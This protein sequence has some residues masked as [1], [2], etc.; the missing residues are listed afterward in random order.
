MLTVTPEVNLRPGDRLRLTLT[1]AVRDT[2]GEGIVT[3]VDGDSLQVGTSLGYW[4]TALADE[5]MLQPGPGWESVEADRTITARYGDVDNDGWLDVAVASGEMEDED[6]VRVYYN[7]HGALGTAAGWTSGPAAIHFGVDLGDVDRDG[8]LDMATGKRDGETE[9]YV[10]DGQGS[11]PSLPGW[12]STTRFITRS[13]AFGDVDNDGWLELATANTYADIEEEKHADGFNEVFGN[14]AG[15]LSGDPVWQSEDD[16]FSRMVIWADI[17]GDGL[18]D[19]CFANMWEGQSVYYNRGGGFP[20]TADW[21]SAD[22]DQTRYIAVHDFDRDGWLD[23]AACNESG[24]ACIYFNLGGELETV[25]SWE[26]GQYR[27]AV[28]VAAGDLDGDGWPDL[29]FGHAWE[30]TEPFD[31]TLNTKT[32]YLNQGGTFGSEPDWTSA[33]AGNTWGLALGDVD[34]DGDLDLFAAE[35]NDGDAGAPNTLYLSL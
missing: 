34:R 28:S 11:F 7:D 12:A 26:S 2:A 22:E 9:L 20:P 1:P 23:L 3:A 18:D 24:Y 25:P 15:E 8:W 10:N 17:N 27:K 6:P 31:G 13:V 21:Q 32:A 35:R 29:V 16:R 14:D 33:N 19:L 30:H 4:A 5:A